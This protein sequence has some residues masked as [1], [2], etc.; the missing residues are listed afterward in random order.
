M[1]EVDFMYLE[2]DDQRIGWLKII[3]LL[4]SHRSWQCGQQKHAML[5]SACH[6]S[7]VCHAMQKVNNLFKSDQ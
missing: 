7:Q 6:S 4:V 5:R 3:H 1:Q 2:I